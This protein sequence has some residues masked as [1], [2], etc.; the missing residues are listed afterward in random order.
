MS[1]PWFRD[2][3]LLLRRTKL[4][5]QSYFG[6]STRCYYVMGGQEIQMLITFIRTTD[7]QS[8]GAHGQTVG[9]HYY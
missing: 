4:H 8:V 1:K 2:W 6:Y 3:S 7:M 9:L 5:S